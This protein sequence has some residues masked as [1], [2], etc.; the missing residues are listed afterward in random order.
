MA[1]LVDRHFNISGMEI[2]SILKQHWTM[3]RTP[4]IDNTDGPK[5]SHMYE[6]LWMHY[7]GRLLAGL[8]VKQ[9][10]TYRVYV[11][12]RNSAVFRYNRYRNLISRK[13]SM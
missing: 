6:L 11:R 1:K 8:E 12:V 2:S 7:I 4:F 10:A 3:W 13:L 9:P 5:L